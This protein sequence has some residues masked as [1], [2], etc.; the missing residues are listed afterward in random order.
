MRERFSF[1]SPTPV[2]NKPMPGG[3]KE[4]MPC[5]EQRQMPGTEN[6]TEEERID[7]AAAQI[8]E[9]YRKAFEELAK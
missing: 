8:L 2:E 9:E 5:R 3:D 7:I 4:Q 1:P 6:K